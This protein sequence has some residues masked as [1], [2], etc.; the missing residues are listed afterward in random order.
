MAFI[1]YSNSVPP[2]NEAPDRAARKF[3]SL[4]ASKK[5]VASVLILL[6][7]YM[8]Y[9]STR[10]LSVYDEGLICYG[11]E[12]VLRGDIP[13][14]DFWTAY[15]PGQYYLLA[16]VFKIFG[17]SL[18]VARIYCVSVEWIVAILAYSISRSLTGPVGGVLSCVAVAVWLSCDRT[19]LYPVIPTLAFALAGFLCLAH[20][21]AIPRNVFLAG[22]LAGCATVVR[23]DLGVYTF[24]SQGVIVLGQRFVGPVIGSEKPLFRPAG[25]L[26]RFIIY[27][28]G[29]SAVVLPV[30]LAL[31]QAVPRQMLYEIFVDF[32]FRIYPQFRSV[33][34]PRPQDFLMMGVHGLQPMISSVYSLAIYGAIYGLPLL[35]LSASGV[36]LLAIRLR[37]RPHN[38]D[39]LAAGLV[40]FGVAVFLSVRVRPDVAHMV[41][42][43]VTPLILLPWLVQFINTSST[44]RSV[45]RSF[46]ILLLMSVGLLISDCI[47]GRNVLPW[48]NGYYGKFRPISIDR[49]KGISMVTDRDGFVEAVQYIQEKTLPD[50]PIYVGNTRHDQIYYNNAMFYF[51]SG[52]RS[53]TRFAELHPGIVT[54]YKVQCEIIDEIKRQ[55]VV[56]IVLWMAPQAMEP[57]RS[58][59]SSGVTILD[60]FIKA[61]Y[62]QIAGFGKY[63]ILRS[64]ESRGTFGLEGLEGEGNG[65]ERMSQAERR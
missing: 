65:T 27:A 4:A 18:L 28:T 5:F 44:I 43:M 42:P 25:E 49:A 48:L 52:R 30:F 9:L 33:P 17:A 7:V 32:P 61:N 37:N 40:S 24:V 62:D 22:L 60:D 16:G 63:L 47:T 51:L 2:L 3:E 46:R 35:I 56:Y 15:G 19:V 59:E 36:S 34:F 29:A 10:G 38:A 50:E 11:A 23:H 58:S 57:N 31:S 1:G 8:M 26:K 45:Y 64:C 39:W 6:L 55:K 53:A 14:R 41:L 13:Y 20:S 21:S 12:R 54:T